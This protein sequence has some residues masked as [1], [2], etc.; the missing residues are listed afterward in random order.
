MPSLFRLS[1]SVPALS[2]LLSTVVPMLGCGSSDD[3]A[4]DNAHPAAKLAELPG[5]AEDLVELS[6]SL[7]LREL[8][9]GTQHIVR[10]GMDGGSET[11]STYP[12]GTWDLQSLRADG[13]HLYCVESEL[14][15]EKWRV[16]RRAPTGAPEVVVEEGGFYPSSWVVTESSVLWCDSSG[17]RSVPKV[18]GAVETV[19]SEGASCESIDADGGWVAYAR[20]GVVRVVEAS[21]GEPRVVVEGV[22]AWIVRIHGSE[23]YYLTRSGE[24]GRAPR[25][26]GPSETLATADARLGLDDTHA[27]FIRNKEGAAYYDVQYNLWRMS[28]AG[29][30]PEEFFVG[31]RTLAY[32]LGSKDVYAATS[33]ALY[34]IGR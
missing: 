24:V 6:G 29:G 2:L 5:M 8:A 3:L 31:E 23:V 22:D 17:I 26:G 25:D 21:G 32:W 27:Y 30:A 16:T 34:R 7:Y 11:L 33:N 14:N 19:A 1:G 15:T 28:L 18:G 10:Y 9:G 13:T 12:L 20:D 4:P